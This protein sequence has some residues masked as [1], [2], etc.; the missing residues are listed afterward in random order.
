MGIDEDARRELR[1]RIC[2]DAEM[3][4][5]KGRFFGRRETT[6]VLSFPSERGDGSGDVALSWPAVRRQAAEGGRTVIEE[7]SVL[8]VHALAHLCGCDHAERR[9]GRLMHRLELRGL[10]ALRVRDIPRSYGL[11]ARREP[12]L[13]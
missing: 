12:A 11:R 4:E 3:A 6:D 1:V 9:E 13:G 5:L 7:A 8:L 10:R 2:D